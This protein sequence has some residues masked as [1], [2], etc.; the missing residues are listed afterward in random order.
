MIVAFIVSTTMTFVHADQRSCKISG[1]TDGGSIEV[2]GCSHQAKIVIVTVSN[3]SQDPANVMVTVKVKCSDNKEY[4][5]TA[6]YATYVPG[7]T[8]S[9]QISI[10]MSDV[11]P[12]NKEI[13]SEEVVSI[14]GNKCAK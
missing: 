1:A 10:N 6:S 4:N 8:D 7:H 11:I 14:T 2:V 12:S 9:K 3:D 5:K 13:I